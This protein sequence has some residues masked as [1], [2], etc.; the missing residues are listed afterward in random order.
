MT[1]KRTVLAYLLLGVIAALTRASWLPYPQWELATRAP[2]VG[3]AASGPRAVVF[4]LFPSASKPISKGIVLEAPTALGPLESTRVL[5][6]IGFEPLQVKLSPDGTQ[7]LHG[8]AWTL[9]F[10]GQLPPGGEARV[11][12]NDL[13]PLTPRDIG[14]LDE[15]S[16]FD[17]SPAWDTASRQWL[18]YDLAAHLVPVASTPRVGGTERRYSRVE[19]GWNGIVLHQAVGTTREF[20][21]R[22][23]RVTVP[24]GVR[25]RLPEPELG[26]W[27]AP[28]GKT[29]IVNAWLP[30]P[31]PE[32]CVLLSDNRLYRCSGTKAS[33]LLR[34]PGRPESVWHQSVFGESL[35]L[36]SPR[37][38]ARIDTRTGKVES[39]DLEDLAPRLFSDAALPYAIRAL[40]PD[41][42]AVVV[43]CRDLQG[44]PSGLGKPQMGRP[45]T[46]REEEELPKS[47]VGNRGT[48]RVY[49]LRFSD[50][51]LREVLRLPD[52]AL[53]PA[54]D[55]GCA[56]G[57]DRNR[58]WVLWF[59]PGG[60]I[61][62]TYRPTRG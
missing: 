52:R 53:V 32:A 23:H 51:H 33:L 60:K 9:A 25:L 44:P 59:E 18:T 21:E 36:Q 48:S 40:S 39:K 56:V 34:L 26:V 10:Y 37:T 47:T 57:G 54:T 55:D 58:L 46:F 22:G 42:V 31:G 43:G 27:L 8:G 41:L 11:F 38:L 13:R 61:C 62:V 19:W 6:E 35:F 50:L 28:H 3:F 49:V 15:Q 17:I 12:R 4:G 7:L 24:S 2:Y 14:E 1:K 20:V 5:P 16:L 29:Y 30:G 45:V